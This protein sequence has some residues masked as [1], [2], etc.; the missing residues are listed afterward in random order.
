M[1]WPFENDTSAVVK[2]LT[3]RS[4]LADKKSN[5]LLIVT[6]ALSVCMVLSLALSTK[7]IAEAQK[8]SYRDKAQITV[9]A[10]TEEQLAQIK[11]NSNVQWIGEYLFLGSSYQDNIELG[12]SYANADYIEK[13]RGLVYSGSLPKDDNEILLE[14]DYID[15]YAPN[16]QV[17]G[18][19]VLDLT[20]TGETTE[21]RISGIIANSENTLGEAYYDVFV[22]KTYAQ[23]LLSKTLDRDFQI[24]A[25]TRLN[26]SAISSGE[27]LSFA[28]DITRPVGIDDEQVFLTDY[29]AVMS[30]VIKDGLYISI[31]LITFITSV[32]AAVVI[33]GIFYTV[34]VKNV[35]TIGQLRTIGMTKRQIKKM[36]R[37]NSLQFSAKGIFLG[38]CLGTV[39]GFCVCPSGFRIKTALMYGIFATIISAF[40]ITIAVRKPIKIAYSTSPIAGMHYLPYEVKKKNSHK[41]HRKLTSANLAKI[42]I[43]RNRGKAIFTFLTLSISGIIF[44]TSALVAGSIDAEKQARFLYFPD[45][46]IQIQLRNA[47]Q[48]TFTA[49][50]EYNYST[51][52]Q[53]GNNPLENVDFIE[54]IEKMDGVEKVTPHNAIMTTIGLPVGMGNWLYRSNYAPTLT[55]EQFS[56]VSDLL[57]AG[58]I[59]YTEMTKTNGIF[60]EDKYASVGDTL[61]LQ[62]RGIDGNELSLD[63][64]VVGT[65][66]GSKLMSVY[67]LVPGN[68]NFLMTY[69]TVKNLTGV[70]AQTG[71]LSVDVT[72]EKYDAV[73]SQ[74]NEIAQSGDEIIVFDIA[75]NISGIKTEYNASI[76]NLYLVSVILFLFG[77]ISLTNTLLVDFK[78]R[79]HEFALLKAI[80]TTQKQ[81]NNMLNR[82]IMTYLAGSFSIALF[83]STI[84][85]IIVCKRL[86]SINH[87]I[88]FSFPWLFL[89]A[90]VALLIIIYFIFSFYVSRELKNTDVIKLIRE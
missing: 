80:G 18:T 45:G 10:P 13:E 48:S 5:L 78:N 30:G 60:V 4:I 46:E 90:F 6:I 32:L 8:D 31:P 72:K 3:K 61:T 17:G 65:Y 50:G 88:R 83:G 37:R 75:Q 54:K 29:F 47:A 39:I 87:C 11:N 76:K 59:D 28:Y 1:T 27:I 43:S 49:N 86:D 58:S 36:V 12:I 52:L 53:L 20:G 42:N 71:I 19:I 81:L 24:T 7:G 26:T 84:A 82:E 73:L 25:Y 34:V 64:P 9:V 89:F 85:S 70:S 44:L 63:V 74:I 23:M 57:T 33:Y 51:F 22:S 62:L 35:Q 41:L 16:C 14:Q 79:K 68:P 55:Q 40:A 2:K 66:D 38:I 67:P 15:H 77:G 21:Y 56:I 69:D